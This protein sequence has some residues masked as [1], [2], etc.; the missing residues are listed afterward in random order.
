M[1][2]KVSPQI[3]EAMT[4][5]ILVPVTPTGR[6]QKGSGDPRVRFFNKSVGSINFYCRL[7]YSDN[8]ASIQISTGIHSLKKSDNILR[9]HLPIKRLQKIM[10][11]AGL[12]TSK[13]AIKDACMNNQFILP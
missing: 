11:A 7:L 6:S 2:Y 9:N 1:H 4:H 8:T 12:V 10:C 13:Q 5:T 3:N